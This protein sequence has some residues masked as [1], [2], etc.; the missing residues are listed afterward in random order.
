[1]LNNL[2][3]NHDI[4]VMIIWAGETRSGWSSCPDN[5]R[6]QHSTTQLHIQVDF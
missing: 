6:V 4:N 2:R 3:T 5:G 1:L